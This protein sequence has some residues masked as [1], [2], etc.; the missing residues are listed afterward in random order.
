M[1]SLL[2]KMED[3]SFDKSRALDIYNYKNI[4]TSYLQTPLDPREKQQADRR[5]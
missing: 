2:A 1:S 5:V 3:G 4:T